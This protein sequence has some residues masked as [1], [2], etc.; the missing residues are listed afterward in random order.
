MTRII[1]AF[2]PNF[3]SIAKVFPVKGKQGIVYAY[4]DTIYNPSG[5]PLPPWIVAHEEVH[6]KQQS[7]HQLETKWWAAYIVS[8]QFRLAMEIEAHIVEWNTY[9]HANGL[10]MEVTRYLDQMATRLS[11][12]L[13]GNML[14][15]ADA[16][17]EIT[18]NERTS[19]AAGR[20]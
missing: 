10:T 2:P 18:G 9:K 7:F 16:I 5:K 1:K 20:D 14:S 13:Y 8:P 12:P 17:K 6:L 15:Y 19:S 3:S 4:G 11:G